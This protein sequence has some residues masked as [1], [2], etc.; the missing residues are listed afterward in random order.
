MSFI[1]NLFY[2]NNR[3][4]YKTKGKSKIIIQTKGKPKVNRRLL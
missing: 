2:K 1:E 4:L 3:G